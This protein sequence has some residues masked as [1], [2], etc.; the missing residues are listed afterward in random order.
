LAGAGLF[1]NV[2]R[3]RGQEGVYIPTRRGTETVQEALGLNL[4]PP[5]VPTSSQLGKLRHDLTVAELAHWLPSRSVPGV[6]WLTWRELGHEAAMA[7]PAGRRYG[8]A[9]VGFLPDGALVLPTE[10]RLAVEVELEEKAST[11]GA[12]L[13]WYRARLA[14]GGYAAVV[15]YCATPAIAIRYGDTFRVAGFSPEEMWAEALPPGIVVWS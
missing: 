1:V 15:W 9:G 6:C 14:T 10:E 5:T 11:L 7:R 3:G 2:S 12:K 13:Q 8:G 4:S